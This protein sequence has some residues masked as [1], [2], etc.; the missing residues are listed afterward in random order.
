MEHDPRAFLWDV[1]HAAQRIETFVQ[2]RGLA[3][4]LADPMLRS[5]VER[6]FEII[7]EALN[8]LSRSAP[9]IAARIPDLSRAVAMRNILIHGYAQ[10]DNEAVWR[11]LQTDLPALRT[12]VAELLT[13][14]GDAR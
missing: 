11:T 2:D 7:G 13:E 6:Q 12:R 10:V 5:A 1:R 4:D 14:L 9:D 8:R 3:D